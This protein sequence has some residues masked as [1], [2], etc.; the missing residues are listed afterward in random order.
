MTSFRPEIL[1]LIPAR[2]GSKAIPR[3]NLVRVA[4]KP[5]IAYTIEQAKASR[6]ITRVVVSTE[7]EEIAAVA[8]EC[9]ADVPFLRPAEFARDDS[10][11]L[12]V[13]LHALTWLKEREDYACELVV[14]LR[15]TGPVRRVE[16]IDEAI[17]QLRAHP[18]ATALR[19]VSPPVQTPYKM[20]R[21][22]GRYLQPLL[23]L[24]G[25]AEPF[26][27]P[28]Q[29]LPEVVWQNGAIDIV[30]PE[31]ILTQRRMCGAR[32]LPFIM[33]EPV[34]EID[35][36]E[37]LP[38]VEEALRNLTRGEPAAPSEPARRHPV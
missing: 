25:V 13:F 35:Y 21:I 3:K 2:G 37:S 31:V 12:D 33:R 17:E 10:P 8:R 36:A 6:H 9:G 19:S 14:H 29:M 23:E 34:F 27:Q 26:C 15:P 22:E 11:D 32:V 30:R 7:D 28:R 20:W 18:E 4:G 16:R 1:A 38:R 5:L 24:P